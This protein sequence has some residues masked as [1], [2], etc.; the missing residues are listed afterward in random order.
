MNSNKIENHSEINKSLKI[1]L[2]NRQSNSYE[3]FFGFD[4]FDRIADMIAGSKISAHYVVISDDNVSRLYGEPLLGHLQK[5][6]ARA[7][8]V[9][10]PAGEG[11]KNSQTVDDLAGKLLD[12]GVD[13]KSALIA[14]GG[15]VAGDLTGYVA[16]VYMRGLPWIQ[17]P[18]TLLAQVDSSI[19]GKTAINLSQGKNLLGT[20][21]QPLYV[22]T[23][24]KCL[25]TLPLNEYQNGLAEIVKNGVIDS[26]TLFRKLESGVDLLLSRSRPFLEEIIPLACGIKKNIVELD[27]KEEDRRRILNFGHTLGHAIEQVS[28]YGISHGHAIAIG[29]IAAA[30]ISRKMDGLTKNDQERIEKLVASLGLGCLIPK[31]MA[32]EDL[33]VAL[34]RDKKKEG[35]TINFVMLKKIGFPV[36]KGGVPDDLLR[37]TIEELKA[38]RMEP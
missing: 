24:I 29:M 10:F 32:T 2:K 9:V 34:R 21:Y 1:R 38:C 8:M 5:S 27:E 3:I 35:D 37:E 25:D 33:L 19:G 22:F 20:F 14:L 26:G 6:T 13:R 7:D 18:T 15:G 36:I 12:L 23:D 4:M 17:I 30:R 16:S 11:S 31:E 28:G